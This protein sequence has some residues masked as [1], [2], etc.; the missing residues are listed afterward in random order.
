MSWRGAEECSYFFL[1]KRGASFFLV[2][3]K[4]ALSVFYCETEEVYYL[5]QKIEEVTT[6]K[7]C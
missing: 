3:K 1:R 2:Q 4:G 6:S 5:R 7:S